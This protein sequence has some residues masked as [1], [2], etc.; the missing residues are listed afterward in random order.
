MRRPQWRAV[1]RPRGRSGGSAGAAATVTNAPE[2][3]AESPASGLGGGGGGPSVALLLRRVKQTWSQHLLL[4]GLH[5]SRL[6]RR[7]FSGG[8]KVR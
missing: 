4:H 6:G 5:P 2:L 1:S 8:P 3:P 7:W